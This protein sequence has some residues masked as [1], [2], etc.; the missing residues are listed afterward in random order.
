M[1]KIGQTLRA[2]C[3]ALSLSALALPQTGT[4]QGQRYGLSNAEVVDQSGQTR[5]FNRDVLGDRVVIVSFTWLGCQTVCPITDRIMQATQAE[6]E[7]REQS[8]RLVTLTLS[9]LSDTPAKMAKRAQTFGAE[10]EWFWLSGD[11]REMRSVL[12]GLNA[13][14][15][16]LS[17]HP[18]AFLV[19][20]GKRNVV[21]RM[22]G[23]PRPAQ[24]IAKAD[25]MLAARE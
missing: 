5:L 8:Y 14:E 19:I 4:A 21:A 1:T 13:L 25:A 7:G 17:E 2:S 22:E 3:L 6:M 23:A 11:F 10:G 12:A 18:P 15:A 9:P 16:N 24:L 20:D